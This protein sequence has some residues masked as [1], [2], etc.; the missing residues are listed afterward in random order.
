MRNQRL[1][2]LPDAGERG[3]RVAGHE[4]RGGNEQHRGADHLCQHRSQGRIAARRT[5]MPVVEPLFGR[6][7]LL[8]E[9]HPRVE[10]RADQGRGQKPETIIAERQVAHLMRD[11]PKIRMRHDCDHQEGQLERAD[12]YRSALDATIRPAEDDDQQ[13]R[14][15]HRQGQIARSAVE[16]ADAGHR[17]ELGGHRAGYRQDQA[18]RQDPCPAAAV[19]I[20]DELAISAAGKDGEPHRQLLNHVENRDQAQQQRQQTVTPLRAAL[21]GSNDVAGI[22]I[23]QHDE[24]ARPDTGDEG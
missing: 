14:G 19:M 22:G 1:T 9:D 15:R 8:V 4:R 13:G 24:D 23:R 3:A 2:D 11:R 10:H 17:G 6:G 20:A 18:G 21:R 12:Q 5:V 16:L 7:R